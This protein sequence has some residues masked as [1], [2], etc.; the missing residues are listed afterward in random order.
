MATEIQRN[1]Q[2]V[3][4]AYAEA[5][6]PVVA[7]PVDVY[8]NDHELLLVADL[9]GVDREHLN[10]RLENEELT[11]EGRWSLEEE[12]SLLAGSFRPMDYRRSFAM[13]QTIDA[14]KVSAELKGGVLRVHLPKAEAYRPR[15]IKVTAG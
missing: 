2:E 5:R 10:L 3:P 14:E 11:I 7:P 12:G 4:T 15:Q 13:P 9:P 1:E 8:E 6:R